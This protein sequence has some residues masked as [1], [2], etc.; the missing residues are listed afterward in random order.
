M[1]ARAVVLDAADVDT[2]QIIPARFLKT[3]TKD[4]LAGALF[5]DWRGRPGFPLDDPGNAGAQ[6]LIAGPNFG[7]GSS[8]E[9]A[10]WALTAWGFRAVIAPGFADI[11][12]GNAL[13]QGL[14]P[15]AIPVDDHARLMA[16]VGRDPALPVTVDLDAQEVRWMCGGGAADGVCRAAFTV[17]PFARRC[18]LDGVDE[19]GF[20]L[21][22]DRAIAAHEADADEARHPSGGAR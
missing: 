14:V 5:A 13:G 12:R 16:A 22:M 6:V 7:C 21:G 17:D 2:D 8:R 9:H 1:T 3:T 15:A 4:D 19:L 10:A 20:L 18:L 11:F